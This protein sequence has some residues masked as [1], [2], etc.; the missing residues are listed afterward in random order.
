M[1][2]TPLGESVRTDR[3]Y[4]DC[5]I[6]VYGRTMCTDLVQLPMHDFDVILGMDWLHSF[7]A[8]LNCHSRVVRFHFPKEELV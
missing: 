7:Y 5:S 3:V 2:S 6:V 1:V 8:C 4:K